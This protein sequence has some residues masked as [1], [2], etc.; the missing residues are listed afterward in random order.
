MHLVQT[1]W[2]NKLT[3][4]TELKRFINSKRNSNYNPGQHRDGEWLGCSRFQLRV[5][6]VQCLGVDKN[7]NIAEISKKTTGA[8][9]SIRRTLTY[10]DRNV[11][12]NLYKSIVRPLLETY[13]SVWNPYMIKHIK[14]LAPFKEEQRSLLV[15]S[16]NYLIM[17]DYWPSSPL[18]NFYYI[19]IMPIWSHYVIVGQ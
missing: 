4:R 13:V 17:K 15:A 8:L 19:I 14:Q 18:T 12:I 11:F 1:I 6:E 2:Q 3:N 16:A 7:R 10:I 9:A 5:S